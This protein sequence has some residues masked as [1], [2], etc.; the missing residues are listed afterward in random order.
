MTHNLGRV[1][2][3]GRTFNNTTGL[4]LS[5][6][7]GPLGGPRF[8]ILHFDSVNLTVG[9]RLEV[10]LGYG[11]DVFTRDSGTN[12]WSRPVDTSSPPIHIRITGG[13]GT[14]RLLEYGSG[15]PTITPGNPPG[16]TVGSQSN[17]DP[18]LHT[19]PYVEPIYETRLKC[20]GF[21]WKQAACVQVSIPEPVKK[22]VAAAVGFIVEVHEGH[23]SSC[24]GTLIAADLFLTSR[25]CLLDPSG[26]DVRSASVTFDYSTNCDGTR[27]LGHVTRFFKV[28]D[29]VSAGTPPPGFGFLPPL[30]SDWVVLRLDSAPGA[31]PPPLEMREIALMNDEVIFTMH[32]PNGAA[33]KAQAGIHDGGSI[34]GFDFAGGS[35][36][37][38]LFD[39][40]GDLVMGPLSRPDP[41]DSTCSVWYTPIAPI[42]SKLANPPPPTI[43]LDV[44]L[45]FDRSGSMAASAPPIGRTKLEE[46]KDAASL[47]VHLVREGQGDRIGLVTFSSSANVNTSPGP[48]ATVKPTLV[49]PA[50][51]TTGQVGAIA[52]GGATSIGGGLATALSAIGS[53]SSNDR[54]M[55]LL[56][57]GLQNTPPMVKDVEGS[58]GSTKLCV[59]GF[60]SDADLDG[61]LLSRIAREHGGEFTRAVDGLT[62][63]KFFGLCFGNIF[64]T[65]A[66]G[67]PEFVLRANQSVSEPHLFSVCDEERI[68]LV[69]GWDYPSTPLRAH[70]TT[71]KGKLLN[72]RKVETIRGRTWVFWRVPLPH[73]GERDGTWQ[74][75]VDRVPV[76]VDDEFPPRPTD[77]RYFLL[78]ISS[79]GPKLVYLG[80]PGRVY[81]G[82]HIDPLIGLHYSNGTS[83]KAQVE[84]TVNAPT[85]ALGKLVTDAGL[86]PPAISADGVD[87]FYATLQSIAHQAGGV[88]PVPTS[89]LKFPLF[90]DG[91]H[92]DGAMEPDGIYNHRL[93]NITCAEGTYQ[94]RAVATYGE[95][96]RSTREALWSIHVEPGIDHDRSTVTVI[97]V[98][99][100]P[101]G[102]H[103]TLVIVP[104]D[105]YANPIGPGRAE[106]FTVSPIPGV[107]IV[108][109]VK[110]QKDGS[111]KVNI[112]WDT[113]TAP[114]PGILIRQPERDPVVMT[115]PKK[116][117]PPAPGYDCKEA[118]EKLLDCLGL[119]DPDVKRVRVKSVN[120]KVDLEDLENYEGRDCND[121]SKANKS[122]DRP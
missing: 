103:G 58:L 42:K 64:E 107:N 47:F 66:L 16:T 104:R 71:P 28:L 30:D 112:V 109:T 88:L 35:S 73:G 39:I 27:P 92:Q 69:I 105:R 40:N 60:G 7:A 19:N 89:M 61:P 20:D 118:A 77:V 9:A 119:D 43:P 50:P 67:D 79:G 122:R 8:V 38:A 94:F 116:K 48:V 95:E 34:S 29:E 76:P 52:A 78:V 5:P 85:I 1:V 49:G 114:V 31:L 12:F 111:Y 83:P 102:R 113:S 91:V 115:P 6:G 4:D 70:I 72:E 90:D 59:I 23:V 51:Y 98:T 110:D 97:N 106:L 74:F 36:G 93:T 101:D 82:D 57:D 24:S 21:D 99:D 45:V 46:A 75:T 41:A 17:P 68:T 32:H 14:A 18:F 120:L 37:S 100:L 22:K 108:G 26:E 96:C 65:G 63:R 87:A 3:D 33:K 13:T 53:G 117:I 84:L 2:P 121:E 25:H 15:E 81:T 80:G 56:T 62:L 55:L 44:M 11:T 54:A 86:C 10:P